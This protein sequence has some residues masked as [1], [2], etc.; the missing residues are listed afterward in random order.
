MAKAKALL[1]L[2]CVQTPE[3][4]Q[5][6]IRTKFRR[7]GFSR[8]SDEESGCIQKLYELFPHDHLVHLYRGYSLWRSGHP[9]D[10][11][12][13]FTEARDLARQRTTHQLAGLELGVLS[14]QPELADANFNNPLPHDHRAA[15][16]QLLKQASQRYPFT[17]LLS[18]DGRYLE[19]YGRLV[20][21]ATQRVYKA[22]NVHLDVVCPTAEQINELGSL[23]TDNLSV[24]IQV[25]PPST[26]KAYF[27]SRR[28]HIASS[29]LERYSTPLLIA[30]VDQFPSHHL[31][32][33]AQ[34]A[35]ALEFDVCCGEY[36]AAWMPWNR[37]IV[38]ES[39]YQ[40]T[41][42]AKDFLDLMSAYIASAADDA[43]GYDSIWWV[44][45]NA[46]YFAKRCLEK[47]RELRF[48]NRHDVTKGK[49]LFC[50]P[51]GIGKAALSNIFIDYADVTNHEWHCVTNPVHFFNRHRKSLFE[52][53]D[54]IL[55]LLNYASPADQQTRAYW[56]DF[57][58]LRIMNESRSFHVGDSLAMLLRELGLGMT[59][60]HVERI[61]SAPKR[62]G[63]K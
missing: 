46:F 32:D 47:S 43:G 33:F 12:H 48:L 55:A 36:F 13:A 51:R 34:K 8:F 59:A 58:L 1:D 7:E 2:E 25:D 24:S 27:A 14:C 37:H 15:S 50:G 39:L 57:L 20:L 62:T 11:L 41:R 56:C 28:F 9:E 29:V 45:Q 5:E 31:V 22:F 53:Q 52:R 35:S 16:F 4:L 30:D 60:R 61:C 26:A 44:D 17:I 19:A 18:C 40:P 3:A 63:K 49:P 38:S 42:Q 21:I 6:W 54:L 23:S 10:A